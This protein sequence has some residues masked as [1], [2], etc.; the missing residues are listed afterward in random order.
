MQYEITIKQIG[1]VTTRE[2][3]E[4]GIV[5]ESPWTEVTLKDAT[6]RYDMPTFLKENPTNKIRGYLPSRDV[7]EVK[8]T[9]VFKQIVDDDAGAVVFRV[10]KAINLDK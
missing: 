6:S 5:A 7:T 10:V 2:Q 8:I 3:G 1:E 4:Y 9:E